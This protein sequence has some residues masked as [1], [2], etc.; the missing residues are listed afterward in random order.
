M[1]MVPLLGSEHI[2]SLVPQLSYSPAL[3]GHICHKGLF[4]LCHPQVNYGGC[5][6]NED[7]CDCP[8]CDRSGC[9]RIGGPDGMTTY[10]W[11]GPSSFVSAEQDP[12]VS[13]A[14]SGTYILT[15]TDANGCQD[16]AETIVVVKNG[17]VVSEEERCGG[18]DKLEL[19]SVVSGG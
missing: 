12:T 14:V 13:P 10:A 16:S 6:S 9:S 8:G 19:L 15:V 17:E 11:T 3:A 1:P 5:G 18:D 2:R 4:S 7:G